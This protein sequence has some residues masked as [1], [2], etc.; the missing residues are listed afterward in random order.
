MACLTGAGEPRD[1]VEMGQVPSPHEVWGLEKGA[2]LGERSCQASHRGDPR[3][4]PPQAILPTPCSC[5]YHSFVHEALLT[6]L[7]VSRGPDGGMA[8]SHLVFSQD[9]QT[10][11]PS[12]HPAL[13][14]RSPSPLPQSLYPCLLSV[15]Q[16]GGLNTLHTESQP[17]KHVIPGPST[18]CLFFFWVGAVGGREA[19][20][21]TV[22]S[23]AQSGPGC[24]L[25]SVDCFSHVIV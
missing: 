6:Q 10:L 18:P 19:R 8:G 12:T 25:F 24:G 9:P 22:S 17:A 5:A 20:Q 23:L 2:P 7:K 13:S 1:R 16:L 14:Q 3:L 11:S 21:F 15:C 4:P